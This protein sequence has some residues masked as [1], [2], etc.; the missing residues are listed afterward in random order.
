MSSLLAASVS[1]LCAQGP[2]GEWNLVITV[3]VTSIISIAT[4]HHRYSFAWLIQNFPAVARQTA[5]VSLF[6]CNY[7]ELEAVCKNLIRLKCLEKL[8]EEH[9]RSWINRLCYCY[10]NRVWYDTI[11]NILCALNNWR[12][13]SSVYTSRVA[14]TR[15]LIDGQMYA[16]RVVVPLLIAHVKLSWYV[17]YMS[18]NRI[19]RTTL[20]Q[21]AVHHVR[22]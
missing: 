4:R 22:K 7:A 19:C 17:Q 8:T 5:S 2:V 13:A 21:N 12:L 6:A 1:C 10:H 15:L 20:L 3:A 16:S 14:I 18:F 9:F 11:W